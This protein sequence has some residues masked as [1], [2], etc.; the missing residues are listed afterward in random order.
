MNLVGTLYPAQAA[1][2]VG[3][4]RF[5]S[6]SSCSLYDADGAGW[7]GED[8]DLLR[9]TP[10]GQTKVLADHGLSLRAYD[11]GGPQPSSPLGPRESE[12][13]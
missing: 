13:A 10:C 3:A 6:S 4:E 2:E 5:L 12:V 1:D 9:V 8:A 7:A 11:P